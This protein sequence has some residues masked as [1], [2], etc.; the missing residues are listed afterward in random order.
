M[1]GGLKLK[2]PGGRGLQRPGGG[3]LNVIK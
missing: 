1:L 2:K 3:G